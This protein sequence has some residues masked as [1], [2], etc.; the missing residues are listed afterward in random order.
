MSA[1]FQLDF[2]EIKKTA[3][4]EIRFHIASPL[5]DQQGL[6]HPEGETDPYWVPDWG[7]HNVAVWN[8]DAGMGEENG[9]QSSRRQPDP[10]KRRHLIV[11]T[12]KGNLY[13]LIDD[14]DLKQRT[15]DF[16]YRSLGP[17]KDTTGRTIKIH[18]RCCA[19]SAD[20]NGDGLQD[21]IVGGAT[22][23]CGADTDPTPGGGIYYLIHNGLD[24]DGT[25]LL[26]PP[27]PP[28]RRPHL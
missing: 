10:P 17:L 15:D 24:D 26:E 13:L 5:K 1:F 8:Y 25:P 9:L 28:F 20:L 16:T 2:W 27:Q 7:Y 12:D 19:A 11:G 4:N 23:Q 6:F 18:N 21:L 22:Y 3:D 14:A